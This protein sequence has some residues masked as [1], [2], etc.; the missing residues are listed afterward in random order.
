M[1]AIL[2]S[3]VYDAVES[4]YGCLDY[5]EFYC[6]YGDKPYHLVETDEEKTYLMNNFYGIHEM[7]HITGDY[8]EVIYHDRYGDSFVTLSIDPTTF[9]HIEHMAD[10]DFLFIDYVLTNNMDDIDNKFHLSSKHINLLFNRS[11][12]IGEFE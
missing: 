4:V 10:V 3:R 6:K 1:F 2:E 9:N 7:V 11:Y 5:G 8:T 12:S